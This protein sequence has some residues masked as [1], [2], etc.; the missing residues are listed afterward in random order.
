MVNFETPHFI[1]T[2][3][4]IPVY[5]HDINIKKR[6]FK[7]IFYLSCPL[8]YTWNIIEKKVLLYIQYFKNLK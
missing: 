1:N 6:L 2:W 8:F 7:D 5:I 3:L 4:L